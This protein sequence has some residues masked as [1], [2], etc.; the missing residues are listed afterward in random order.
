MMKL[1]KKQI[2]QSKPKLKEYFI[3]VKI[4][5]IPII[6]QKKQKICKKR[7]NILFLS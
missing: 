2:K 3:K 7:K 5:S 4:T 6:L 1:L